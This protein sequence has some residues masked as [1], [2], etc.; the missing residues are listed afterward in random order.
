MAFDHMHVRVSTLCNIV[1]PP[2]ASS[3]GKRLLKSTREASTALV[4]VDN[5]ATFEVHSTLAVI[6]RC[7]LSLIVV[8]TS[9]HDPGGA[10]IH[11]YII[12]M[13]APPL[14][15]QLASSICIPQPAALECVW[16]QFTV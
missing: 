6:I 12:C 10:P 11:V 9:V 8:H 3:S 13:H 4:E 15:Y 2:M 1:N 7:L 16:T 14:P 5:I